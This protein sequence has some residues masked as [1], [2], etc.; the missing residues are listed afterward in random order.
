MHLKKLSCSGFKSFA[1]L[2]EFHF[3]RGFTGIV[4]PNGCGKSNVVDAFRW[5]LGE[6]SA[7][8][9][10]G[11]E[12]LDV[13]FKGTAHRPPLSRAEVGL[14]F[15]NSDGTLPIEHSE[16][17]V[18]RRLYRSGES[19]YLL[20]RT[21]CRLKDILALFHGTGIGTE[22]YSILEQGSVDSFLRASPQ[23]RR[24]IFE[25]AAGISKFRKDRLSTMKQIDRVETNLARTGDILTEVERRIRSVKIQAGRA[26]RFLEDKQAMIRLRVVLG[27]SDLSRYRSEREQLT[28]R[29][30]ETDARRRL[31]TRLGEELEGKRTSTRDE[32]D[33]TTERLNAI[34]ELEMA[35]KMAVERAV[36]RRKYIEERR[37]EIQSVAS[38]RDRQREELSTAIHEYDVR[39]T[40]QRQR[41]RREIEALRECRIE[42]TQLQASRAELQQDKKV[43]TDQIKTTK[44]AALQA[45]F[46][47]T[48]LSNERTTLESEERGLLNRR[49]RRQSELEQF[50]DERSGLEETLFRLQERREECD[51]IL[52]HAR[53]TSDLLEAEI[54]RRTSSLSENQR[55]V[56]KLREEVESVRARLGV[57]E[58][59]ERGQEGIGQGAQDLLGLEH[60][61]RRDLVGLLASGI[62]ADPGI[63]PLVDAVLGHDAETVVY[64]DD[65]PLA[66][67]SR[68][69]R[70]VLK[71]R[72]ATIADVGQLSHGSE[73][74][75]RLE[76]EATLPSGGQ[77][78]S[79]LVRSRPVFRPLIERLLGRVVLVDFVSDALRAL[80]AGHAYRYVTRAGELVEP[81][82]AVTLPAGDGMG[83][84][85]RRAELQH[86]KQRMD[87]EQSVLDRETEAGAAL[88]LNLEARRH[89]QRR[90][91][92][93]I[94]RHELEVE[95]VT[96]RHGEVTGDLKRLSDRS[97]VIAHEVREIDT[98]RERV[99]ARQAEVNVELESAQE[100]QELLEQEV[101]TDE[102][103]ISEVEERLQ[104]VLQGEAQARVA[105]TQNE[106]R[107]VA[108]RRAERE[109]AGEV[110]E[111]RARIQFLD[112]E[113][114]EEE[115]RLARF[116]EEEVELEAVAA[117][118]R[119]ALAEHEAHVS[120]VTEENAGLRDRFSELESLIAAIRVE[121]E[122]LRTQREKDLIREN[123]IGVRM[124]SIRQGLLDELEIDLND[125]PVAEWRADLRGETRAS[126]EVSKDG[127]LT[128][129]P[130]L[131]DGSAAEEDS[132][133]DS[134]A[135]DEPMVT[136]P[137]AMTPTATPE[138]ALGRPIAPAGATEIEE[139][140]HSEPF[141]VFVTRLR[142]ELEDVQKRLKK[143]ANVNLEAMSELN[144][145]EERQ[146]TL[147]VQLDDLTQSRDSLSEIME[148][149]NEKCRALFCETF[150]RAKGYFQELF[151]KIF[152]GGK[153]D[154]HL[155]EGVDELEAGVTVHAT[156]PGKRINSL[157][158][159]S[160]G[161]KA[162]TAVAVLFALFKTRPSPFCLL[163]EV[164]APLDEANN[165]RYVRILEEFAGMAQFIVITHS[166]V[167]MEQAETLYGVT[168]EEEGVSKKLSVRLEEVDRFQ[169]APGTR[170][171]NRQGKI[172]DI[173]HPL[174]SPKAPASP[175]SEEGVPEEEASVEVLPEASAEGEDSVEKAASAD[176][177]AES[178]APDEAI[179]GVQE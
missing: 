171:K 139:D 150:A 86:L 38:S 40:D 64:W 157:Q 119:E 164:D 129:P 67:R 33:Q 7:K 68:V 108:A 153:A 2:T 34:R 58:D 70:D 35:S 55:T 179:A 24:M 84:V 19:E 69:L 29:L 121:D 90:V 17:E 165:R 32:L 9:L 147:S 160:G 167:T 163:D 45:V 110:E 105:A 79:S 106:E 23:E 142:S 115:A 30:V 159:M 126:L 71:G 4:G 47:Q 43:L 28:Y 124:D 82:G 154:L 168:M 21:R 85:S 177:P 116:S 173:R 52:D 113:A 122:S 62:E 127:E 172:S 37:S 143:N 6:R 41:L 39:R 103:Q 176:S 123:E 77:W 61:I 111:R 72:G 94:Q 22:G 80:A 50:D 135:E 145:L 88:E 140:E 15:D 44:E 65:A 133:T 13:I 89:E 146:H 81:W 31:L 20:N 87:R 57:L 152:G 125:A 73:E 118:E 162:L 96:R 78:L 136:G 117:R 170:Q 99:H 100:K 109:I 1:D 56:S 155:E 60:P 120:A 128:R 92:E 48:R 137:P 144:E 102:E 76:G 138:V 161:E 166:K 14:T 54:D 26:Q 12:M 75:A 27:D 98:T 97:E 66:D 114:S 149:L 101:A 10:R 91:R 74:I 63:A 11:K 25:E 107:I 49:E 36:D 3:E 18:T 5:V 53:E 93:E 174:L 156:P 16:V 42:L 134:S 131:S 151:V 130:Q 158:L 8:G 169:D 175:A 141:E 104:S 95:T 132:S 148:E 83:L 178:S 51:R 46:R 112:R 59:L